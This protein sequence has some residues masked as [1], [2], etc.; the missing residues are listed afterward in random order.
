MFVDG[1]GVNR[2]VSAYYEDLPP[3]KIAIID[4]LVK[5]LY[6]ETLTLTLSLLSLTTSRSHKAST[7]H[8]TDHFPFTFAL[9]STR[10][11]SIR[12]R[13]SWRSIAR[14]LGGSNES[15]SLQ[16][17]PP[18]NLLNGAPASQS[19]V[20]A[21]VNPEVDTPSPAAQGTQADPGYDGPVTAAFHIVRNSADKTQRAD[22]TPV[23]ATDWWLGNIGEHLSYHQDDKTPVINFSSERIPVGEVMG[24][25]VFHSH[26]SMEQSLQ[27]LIAKLKTMEGKLAY[28]LFFVVFGISHLGEDPGVLSVEMERE[29][30][31]RLRDMFKILGTGEGKVVPE[32]DK[33]MRTCYE[34]MAKKL[35]EVL[36]EP[37]ISAQDLAEKQL[38][39]IPMEDMHSIRF[40]VEWTY[41]VSFASSPPQ[42]PSAPHSPD[43]N[44]TF[45]PLRSL[46]MSCRPGS[47]AAQRISNTIPT[48]SLSQRR[49]HSTHQ[50]DSAQTEPDNTTPSPTLPESSAEAS[51]NRLSFCANSQLDLSILRLSTR[52]KRWKGG[53]MCHGSLGRITFGFF[54]LERGIWIGRDRVRSRCCRWGKGLWNFDV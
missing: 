25:I 19:T 14:S 28:N 40:V 47:I 42:T 33:V 7:T 5:S 10:T 20:A 16:G 6:L 36:V 38:F 44:V 8:P 54:R 32:D 29:W 24:T 50:A 34:K 22:G 49:V 18:T 17:L 31:V 48:K 39:K 35:T 52:G 12:F 9:A 53:R 26:Q 45:P 11:L 27:R 51:L 23:Q 15:N 43:L 30:W 41:L 13:P 37:R 21:Q 46:R 1:H 4:L 2:C 3:P